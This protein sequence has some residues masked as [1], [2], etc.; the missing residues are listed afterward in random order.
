[1]FPEKVFV[2]VFLKLG[3]VQ[4]L[5]SLPRSL[6]ASVLQFSGNWCPHT[7]IRRRSTGRLLQPDRTRAR[8]RSRSFCYLQLI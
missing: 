7:D 8:G 2:G 4:R 5:S 6:S 1:M 3:Y